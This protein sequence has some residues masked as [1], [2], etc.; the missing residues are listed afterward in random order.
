MHGSLGFVINIH[1]TQK[2]EPK[3][4]GGYCEPQIL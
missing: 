3:D 1:L 2:L 4:K